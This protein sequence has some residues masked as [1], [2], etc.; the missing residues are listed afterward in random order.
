MP[1]FTRP[2]PPS[3]VV[4]PAVGVY[5]PE[6]PTAVPVQGVA[7]VLR[8]RDLDDYQRM[9]IAQI[10]A[11]QL[12]GVDEETRRRFLLQEQHRYNLARLAAAAL[13]QTPSHVLRNAILELRRG[14]LRPRG[15][16]EPPN[17]SPREG[18]P[19][20]PALFN[21]INAVQSFLGLRDEDEDDGQHGPADG[22]WTAPVVGEQTPAHLEQRNLRASV[23]DEARAELMAHLAQPP[24]PPAF[25]QALWH[26]LATEGVE[27][28]GEGVWSNRPAARQL[29]TQLLQAIHAAGYEPALRGGC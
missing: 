20:R 26:R 22:T 16:D 27:M 11:E 17:I 29:R 12:M 4:V 8:T 23:T 28:H 5:G 19:N 14:G 18:N 7:S 25:L 24:T 3:P 2:A 15:R 6:V 13:H 10:R 1:P 21:F 9:R